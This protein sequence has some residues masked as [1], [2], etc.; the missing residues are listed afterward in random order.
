ADERR[1]T[2]A[3]APHEQQVRITTRISH[4]EFKQ[5]L[6]NLPPNTEIN[7]FNI[8]GNFVWV[9]S[10]RPKLFLAAGIGITPFRALI[11]DRIHSK[12]PLDATLL[13]SSSQQPALFANELSFWQKTDP[14]LKV[15]LLPNRITIADN[16]SLIPQWLK[17]L[18][19]V[20]GPSRMVE[21]I[22]IALIA[23]GLPRKQLK[24][25]MFTGY[26]S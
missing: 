6:A 15:H 7:G 25:D 14:T 16:A 24:T 2:I 19:Y 5:S 26:D 10:K 20:S 18:M 23:H 13:Y 17:N 21:E 3:S 8:E 22:A 11:A 12:T 4:S 1:F 9:A